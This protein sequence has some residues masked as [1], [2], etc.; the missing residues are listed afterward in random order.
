LSGKSAT[1]GLSVRK[2]K[3][4]ERLVGKK[5]KIAGKK[6]REACDA[7]SKTSPA[8]PNRTEKFTK[9][10]QWGEK[11]KETG[12]RQLIQYSG[13][14]AAKGTDKT[15]EKMRGPRQK[16]SQTLLGPTGVHTWKMFIRLVGREGGVG[17]RG[18]KPTNSTPSKERRGWKVEMEGRR[19]QK[20]VTNDFLWRRS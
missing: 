14:H 1:R 3:E 8:P 5:A 15:R 6:E 13:F 17:V 7:H 11:S 4:G 18:I 16:W 10:K 2:G 12:Q 19:T 20:K 9:K